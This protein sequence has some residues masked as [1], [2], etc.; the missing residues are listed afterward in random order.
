MSSLQLICNKCEL[1]QKKRKVGA[2]L[3]TAKVLFIIIQQ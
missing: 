1:I 3:V 2:A